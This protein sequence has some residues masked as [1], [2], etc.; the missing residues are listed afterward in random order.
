MRKQ[1]GTRYVSGTSRFYRSP[2]QS[3]T[4]GD[5]VFN[6]NV[7]EHLACSAQRYRRDTQGQDA[8]AWAA[9][10]AIFEWNARPL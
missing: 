8:L 7:V 6:P 1:I 5:Q 4:F 3:P 2:V 10:I 9:A